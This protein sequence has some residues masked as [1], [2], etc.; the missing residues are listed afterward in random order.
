MNSDEVNSD[1]ASWRQ[2][3]ALLRSDEVDNYLTHAVTTHAATN[4]RARKTKESEHE[5]DDLTLQ[6]NQMM[7]WRHFSRVNGVNWITTTEECR[8]EDEAHTKRIKKWTHGTLQQMFGS[9]DDYSDSD[10][11]DYEPPAKKHRTTL[12]PNSFEKSLLCILS[13]LEQDTVLK[14]IRTIRCT[15]KGYNV[16][17]RN[18]NYGRP[19]S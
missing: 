9:Y 10:N 8:I 13:S 6:Y 17:N 7:W 1:A 4:T 2:I 3:E 11:G 19:G 18:T 15:Q 16:I 14:P 12:S 5:N